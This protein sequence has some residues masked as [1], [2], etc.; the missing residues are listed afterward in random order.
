[1][2]KFDEILKE[3]LATPVPVKGKEGVTMDPMEAMVN[4]LMTNAMKGDIASISF[5][6]NMTNVVNPEQESKAQS[7][8]TQYVA[9]VADRLKHQLMDENA[10]DGQQ[11]EVEMLADIAIMVEKISR[12]MAM[13]DFQAV[14]TD[15]RTGKQTVSPLIQLRDNQREL[16]DR[17]FAKLRTEAINR[18]IIRKSLK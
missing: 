5:I 3:K 13:P 8:Y 6:R 1:M 12:Q 17:Q 7:E 18:Q 10:W 15:P 14:I 9:D 4:A 11:T 16:F 2:S